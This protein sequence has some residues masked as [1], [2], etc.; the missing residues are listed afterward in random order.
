M[1]Q[2]TTRREFLKHGSVAIAGMCAA[3]AMPTPSRQN[4]MAAESAPKS[5]PIIDTHQH[6]WDLDKFTL[7][8]L[9]NDGVDVL[10]RSY[11]MSDYLEATKGANVVRTVYMEVNVDPS[12]HVQEAEYVIDLCQRDDNPMAAAV[13][14]GS[15]Q[16][17]DFKDYIAKFADNKYIKGVRTVLHDPDRPQGMCLEPQFVK[18]IQLLGKMG[19]RYDLCLRPGEILDGARLAEKCPQTQFVIDHCGNLSVQN[20]DSKLEAS[21]KKG[22]QAL[23]QLDNVVCKISGI[24]VT[25]DKD[26]WKPADLAP[27]VNFCMET[28][29]EDR[30]FF[31]GDWP[32]CTL[33]APFVAW[34]D[35]LKLIVRDKPEAFQRKLFHDNAV[36]FYGLS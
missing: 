34:A 10:R 21:W 5:I 1:T 22:M 32:V 24:I 14:G 19:L 28:F 36:R 17:A 33:T 12:Q 25:A 30:A 3:N 35:A 20:T 4:V 8:W 26:K 27:N 7:P 31:A 18:N 15:P 9:K 2:P 23:A 16:S 13:I 29:G 11:V 6:L